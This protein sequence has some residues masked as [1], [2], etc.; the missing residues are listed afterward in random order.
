MHAV[1]SFRKMSLVAALLLFARTLPEATAFLTAMTPLQMKSS[2]SSSSSALDFRNLPSVEDVSTDDFNDQVYHGSAIVKELSA[3]LHFRGRGIGGAEPVVNNSVA[4]AFTSPP[5]ATKPT[6]PSTSSITDTTPLTKDE[7]I[8][9][10]TDQLV[11]LLTAQLSHQDGIRG[12][13]SAY[14]TG[15]GQDTTA[16]KEEIPDMLAYAMKRSNF[17]YLTYSLCMNLIVPT[18]MVSVHRKANLEGKLNANSLKMAQNSA[19][20]AMRTKRI[21]ASLKGSINMVRNWEAIIEAASSMDKRSGK[22]NS[23]LVHVSVLYYMCMTGKRK[24]SM[25]PHFYS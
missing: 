16:D 12:F 23:K 18:A 19:T 7:T 20:V 11:Q 25:Y 13:F 6:R 4:E 10:A 9:I 21:L 14:L 5:E 3:S 22:S 8:A 1:R 15:E 17:E 24:Q 2:S